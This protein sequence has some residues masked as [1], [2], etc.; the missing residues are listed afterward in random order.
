MDLIRGHQSDSEMVMV[1]IVPVEEVAAEGFG[2]LDAAK[3]F[4]NCG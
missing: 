4:G 3:R 2:V 1:L